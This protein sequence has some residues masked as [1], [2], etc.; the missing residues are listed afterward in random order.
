MKLVILTGNYPYGE[1]EAF[2][3]P[4]M[5]VFERVFESIHILTLASPDMCVT[6]YIPE[7]ASVTRVNPKKAKNNYFNLIRPSVLREIMFVS[8]NFNYTLRESISVML[9]FYEKSCPMFL[10]Y[11]E[12]EDT[13]NTVFYS[14]WLS[15]YAYVLTRFKQKHPDAFCISRA[16]RVDNF[17][18][19]KAAFYR[20]EILSTLDGIYPISLEGKKEIENR[21]FP[22]IKGKCAKLKVFHLGVEISDIVNPPKKQDKMKVVSCSFIHK[23]KRLDIIID[24]LSKIDDIDIEW[25]HFG[26]GQDEAQI[27]RTAKEKLGW[28][29]NICFNF[30]GQT[31]HDDILDYYTKNHVDLFINSSDHEGIPVSIMEAMSAGIICAAREVG[32]NAELVS[33]KNGFLLPPNAGADEYADVIKKTYNLDAETLSKMKKC[34]MLKVNEEFASPTVYEKFADEIFCFYKNKKGGMQA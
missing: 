33:D 26:S 5:R 11:L 32:G 30:R 18:D 28:K 8:K 2:L 14:Y 22:H 27:I 12:K 21:I 15:H 20:R 7:N 24:A 29:P 4:E 34:A 23:L 16:H 3:E 6:R 10:K 25:T 1:Q 31:A 9:N 19:F 13:S 17:I